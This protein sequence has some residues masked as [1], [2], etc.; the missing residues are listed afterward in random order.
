MSILFLG[1]RNTTTL[2]RN[3]STASLPEIQDRCGY[4]LEA[5]KVSQPFLGNSHIVDV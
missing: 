5:F 2:A 4:T 1:A 3:H